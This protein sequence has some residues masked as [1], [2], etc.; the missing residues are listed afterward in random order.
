MFSTVA[1]VFYNPSSNVQAFQFLHL[2]NASYFLF[3]VIVILVGVRWYLTVGMICTSQMTK[4][5]EH[6]SCASWVL[7]YFL[8]GRI[9]WSPLPSFNWVG[10]LC[11]WIVILY[12]FWIYLIRYI[13][14][15]HFLLFCRLS[16]NFCIISFEA[17]NVLILKFN[18]SNFSVIAR[19]FGIIP[20][21]LLPNW[22]FVHM[23]VFIRLYSFSSYLDCW[24]ILN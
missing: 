6:L 11:C 14:L 3:L 8:K 15:E 22:W 19:A 1:V 17:Q 18:L 23:Y 24:S 7:V 21:N 16:L 4:D 13:I 5:F 20:N 9:Y 2:T 12:I 10:F